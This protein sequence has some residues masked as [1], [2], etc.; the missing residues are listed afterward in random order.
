MLI[1][2]LRAYSQVEKRLIGA[3]ATSEL[4]YAFEGGRQM[5]S[6]FSKARTGKQIPMLGPIA[7]LFG[8]EKART[9]GLV[10]LPLGF[11]AYFLQEKYAY[12]NDIALMIMI[13][14]TH[15]SLSISDSYPSYLF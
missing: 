3:M 10:V 2:T 15:R 4:S 11:G 7:G 1:D 14:P 12:L 9:I 8:A 5:C 6:Y 13:K